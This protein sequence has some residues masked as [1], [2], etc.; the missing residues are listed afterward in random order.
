MNHKKGH[1]FG[2]KNK[3]KR[4]GERTTAAGEEIR[5]QAWKGVAFPFR[6]S[7]V[8]AFP[9]QGQAFPFQESL[10]EAFPFQEQEPE[11]DTAAE[12][13]GTAAEEEATAVCFLIRTQNE[14]K[15]LLQT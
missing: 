14:L 1:L 12:E 13:E 7:L 3:R 10:E 9:F 6:E 11:K 15:F 4:R 2:T 5:V 8:E